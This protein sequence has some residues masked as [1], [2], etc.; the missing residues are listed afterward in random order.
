MQR[1]VLAFGCFSRLGRLCSWC[2]SM[3]FAAGAGCC[4][5]PWLD[6]HLHFGILADLS[7]IPT[8][9]SQQSS[10][11]KHGTFPWPRYGQNIVL[12]DVVHAHP[13][14]YYYHHHLINL[15][16]VIHQGKTGGMIPE[17]RVPCPEV[18]HG[19]SGRH[20][21]QA[22]DHPDVVRLITDAAQPETTVTNSP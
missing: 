3:S 4:N 14:V 5:R 20:Q 7:R 19:L 10:K 8:E 2:C 9:P 21:L 1:I 17:P 22:A 16:N 11:Y 6:S 12:L 18:K 13:A 15:M